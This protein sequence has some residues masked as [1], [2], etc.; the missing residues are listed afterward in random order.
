LHEV[1][2][3]KALATAFLAGRFP[4][5]IVILGCEPDDVSFGLAPS[6]IVGESVKRLLELVIS[7]IERNQGEKRIPQNSI[8]NP[9]SKGD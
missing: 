7:E 5:E 1:G 4:K 3:E 6:K 8:F 9:A 2:L